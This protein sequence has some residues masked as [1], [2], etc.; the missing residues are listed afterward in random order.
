MNNSL[1]QQFV[2]FM[3]VLESKLI[4]I[5]FDMAKYP[6]DHVCFRVS[7][8][9]SYERFLEDFTKLSSMYA[10]RVHNGRKFTIF[11]LK[12]PIVYKELKAHILE[13]S[14]PG[15]SDEYEEGFQHIEFISNDTMPQLSSDSIISENTYIKWQDKTVIKFTSEPILNNVLTK[16][17]VVINIM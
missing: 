5:D 8:L 10:S 3:S 13:Y 1:Q 9:S 17:D 2:D 16:G 12:S 6:M 11:L 14:E 4:D 15:G 7:D